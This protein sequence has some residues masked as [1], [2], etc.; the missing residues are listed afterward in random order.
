MLSYPALLADGVN[1]CK[2]WR[3]L[4]I[5]VLG[6]IKGNGSALLFVDDDVCGN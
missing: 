4:G 6:Y 2:D 5:V 1:S 3:F